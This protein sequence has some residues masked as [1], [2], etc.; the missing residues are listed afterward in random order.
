MPI[1]VKGPDGVSISFPD[2]TG[3]DTI[4]SVMSQ[5]LGPPPQ[6][7][8]GDATKRGTDTQEWAKNITAPPSPSMSYGDRLKSYFQSA[9]ERIKGG[10]GAISEA[11]DPT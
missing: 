4:N 8:I 6:E 9:Q 1:D 10:A 7:K 3:S 2:G 5:H 11:T